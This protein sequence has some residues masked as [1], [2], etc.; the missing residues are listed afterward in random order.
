MGGWRVFAQLPDDLR[1][2]IKFL[3]IDW[4][5]CKPA[6]FSSR[7]KFVQIFRG[8]PFPF[9]L[10][11]NS[12][13]N[14]HL[15]KTFTLRFKYKLNLILIQLLAMI[16]GNENI[17]DFCES[18]RCFLVEQIYYIFCIVAAYLNLNSA[19]VCIRLAIVSEHFRVKFKYHWFNTISVPF[20]QYS[21]ELLIQYWSELQIL[22]KDH[23]QKINFHRID[24]RTGSYKLSVF[25]DC[26]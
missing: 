4:L 20:K 11:V 19:S 25:I 9:F 3:V 10:N 22:G 23:R 13:F 8:F 15:M 14:Q 18:N 24:S 5:S 2:A 12:R 21:A 1:P 7:V 16:R 17:W 6:F 26:T